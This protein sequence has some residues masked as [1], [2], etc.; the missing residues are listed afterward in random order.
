MEVYVGAFV[1]SKRCNVNFEIHLQ[2]LEVINMTDEDPKRYVSCFGR[3]V[4]TMIDSN[5]SKRKW[6]AGAIFPTAYVLQDN[7]ITSAALANRHAQLYSLN[8][9][10]SLLAVLLTESLQCYHWC[11]ALNNSLQCNPV[12]HRMHRNCRG[13]SCR[14]S[15]PALLRAMRIRK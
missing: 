8:K 1:P 2:V 12:S 11:T 3:T 6:F 4:N 13:T 9:Y 7:D 10:Q 5:L 15:A 14:H